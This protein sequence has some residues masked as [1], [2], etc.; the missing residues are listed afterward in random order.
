MAAAEAGS[1]GGGASGA[2][3]DSKHRD[4]DV[5]GEGTCHVLANYPHT[6]RLHTRMS[7][8]PQSWH[9]LVRVCESRH[10]ACW[11]RVGVLVP[12]STLAAMC[13][14]RRAD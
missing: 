8:P 7:P 5:M 13:W 11:W 3:S 9:P 6:P 12:F 4:E 10:A 14:V 2:H 1:G